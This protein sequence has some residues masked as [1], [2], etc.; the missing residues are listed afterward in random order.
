IGPDELTNL[1]NDLIVTKSVE[2]SEG[3]KI[4]D[5]VTFTIKYMNRTAQPITELV[6]SDNLT[7]R[8]E[9]VPGSSESFHP[10]T[11]T[12]EANEKG[13]VIVRF[14]INVAVQPGQGGVVKFKAKVR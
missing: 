11:P 7:P 6:I 9:Y 2:P 1:P 10:A 4:G 5:V 3:V 13:S 14:A 8:F 12:T